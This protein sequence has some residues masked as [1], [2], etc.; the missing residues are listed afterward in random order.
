[1]KCKIRP[2]EIAFKQFWRS[3]RT[4]RISIFSWCIVCLLNGCTTSN[5]I[6]ALKDKDRGVRMNAANALGD[7]GDARAVE[8]LCIALKDSDWYVRINAA[9]AL[10]KIGDA[11][12]VEPLCIALV[13]KEQDVH[14]AALLVLDEMGDARAGESPSKA[15]DRAVRMNSAT[16]LGEIG[17]ARAVEPLC[18][19]LVDKE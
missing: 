2:T 8:P 17:D 18:I 10:G 3:I 15:K 6:S 11:R 1:M 13:D 14:A 7:I 12:A 5:Y 19:A 16:A 4:Q 9:C